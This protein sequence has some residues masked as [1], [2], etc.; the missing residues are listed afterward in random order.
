MKQLKHESVRLLVVHCTATKCNRPFS[1]ENLIA[2]GEAKYGQC[3]YHY[4]VRRNGDVIPL[5]PETVQGVHARHYN[6]CSLGIVYE[7]G[8]DENGQPTDTR[9]EAQKHSLYELLKEL[10]AEYPDARII[11]HCELPKQRVPIELVLNW[12]SRD[13]SRQSQLPHV[14]KR[15]PCFPASIEYA[16][17]QPENRTAQVV[18][19]N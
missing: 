4:Y 11:G 1:V 13:S 6:Y 12:P 8:L 3:S 9:T 10:T 5:L 7:G 18:T 17:L 2:C 14:A 19:L 16:S 15:C